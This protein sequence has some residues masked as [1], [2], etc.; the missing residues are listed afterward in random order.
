MKKGYEFTYED[1]YEIVM[2]IQ[3]ARRL[4]NKGKTERAERVLLNIEKDLRGVIY[5]NN[6]LEK[7][8]R[9]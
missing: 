8:R 9:N 1:I 7:K 5:P 2:R 3:N 6:P 4:I